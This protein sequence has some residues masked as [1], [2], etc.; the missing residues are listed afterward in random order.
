VLVELRVRN[1]GVIDDLLVRLGPGM[2]ALTGE[3]GAGKTLIVEA[4]E[5]LMGGRADAALVR[6]GAEAALVEGRFSIEP[7]APDTGATELVLAREVPADGRS[8][9]YV[10]GRM[11]TASVLG[12]LGAGLL[13]LY[14]QHAHQSLLHQAAQREALDRFAGVDTV[15][16]E[17]VRAEL[18]AIDEQLEALGGDEQARAREVDLL[19][20]QVNELD[21][22]RVSDPGELALLDAE[23]AVL[24][25]AEALRA[26]AAAA[27]ALLADEDQARDLLGSAARALGSFGALA[28]LAER[29]GNVEG[30]LDDIASELRERWERFQEDPERL[31][32]LQERKRLLGELRRKYGPELADVIAFAERARRR[33]AELEQ[34]DSLR[35][36]LAGARAEVLSRLHAL[37]QAIGDARRAGAPG[38]AKRIEAH[39]RTLGLPRARF[40]VRVGQERRGDDVEFCFGANAG[41]RTLPLAK[42]A[43]GGELS[44]AMLATRLVLSEAP[45]TLVFDEVDAGIGGEAALHVGRALAELGVH[46]QVLVV[47]HLAQVAAFASQQIA[48]EKHTVGDRTLTTAREVSGDERLSELSRMLSG[49]PESEAARRHA[50]ELL[51][52]ASAP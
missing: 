14:G 41:E 34:S 31:A 28:D 42:A 26:A 2:T 43:S 32:E 38:L 3:T 15:V 19:A 11:A 4:L 21:A 7:P 45:P 37:E 36:E 22:A 50:R 47:T 25:G 1:L 23:E 39:L 5:L 12:E 17:P 13:D 33:L 52:G 49:Q 24:A 44:R 20:Y 16:L 29:L 27:R 35:A 8:R 6:S 51:Q 18:A 9:A 10:D 46:H 48:V 40:E 30:E